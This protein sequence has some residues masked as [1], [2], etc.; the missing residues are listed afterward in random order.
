[1][2]TLE[3]TKELSQEVLAVVAIIGG[4]IA[5]YRAVHEMRSAT[6]QRHQE[7]RWKRAHAAKEVLHDIHVDSRAANA[8]TMLD[9]HDGKHSYTSGPGKSFSISYADVLK[10]IS[11]PA[12]ECT[13]DKDVF[14]R[15]CFDW[16]LYHI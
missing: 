1:M 15:D 6:N 4:C 3:L 10:A 16:F 8:V 11:C 12:N 9:W 13:E 7:L 2:T 14:I 5:A